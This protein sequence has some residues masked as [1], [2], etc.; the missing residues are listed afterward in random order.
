MK[1]IV[2]KNY[3]VYINNWESFTQNIDEIDPSQIFILVDENTEKYCLHLLLEKLN[4]SAQVIRIPSGERYKNLDTCQWIWAQLLKYGADRHSLLLNLG[5]GVIGDMGGFCAATYMRGI[6]FMQVPTTLLSQVD[7]SVGGKLA[8]DLL[9]FK[10]MIGLIKDPENVF[11]F[12]NFLKSLPKDQIR[13]GYAELLKHG[14]IADKE[15]WNILSR[16]DD[17]STLDYTE[18]VYQS[19][20][21]KKKVTEQDPEEKGIRKIL[22][23]GHTVGHAIESYWL[24]S[25]TPLLHGDAIAIGM[26]SEAYLSYRVGKINEEELYDIRNSLLR[27]YGHHP[28]LV[29]PRDKIIEIMK[30]DKKNKNGNIQFAL[31]EDVGHACFDIKVE[32]DMIEDSFLYYKED[33]Y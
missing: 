23:F 10:N 27:I 30:L 2:C 21:V 13:S 11:I 25:K 7:A 20:I 19:V 9:G 12:T 4:R 17:I 33:V 28:H 8:V 1:N 5:G 22:N 3:T 31:L 15:T 32:Q 6:K 18:L 26:V 24:D 29:G 16:Q 14:L